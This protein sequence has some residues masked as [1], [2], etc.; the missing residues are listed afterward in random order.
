[1]KVLSADTTQFETEQHK[2]TL[3]DTLSVGRFEIFERLQF[4]VAWGS[5]FEK[6]FN[7]VKKAYEK[8]NE[9]K[10]AD[11][12]VI[13]Y[14]AMKGIARLEE[15]PHPVLR[16]CTLFLVR[17]GE[18]LTVWDEKIADEK[19]ADWK[20]EG[21]NTDYFFALALNAVGGFLSAYKERLSDTSQSRTGTAKNS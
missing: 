7:N 9:M 1:M 12:S 2:Y 10:A 19:I 4:E 11:A 6:L 17:D 21:I 18:D 14:N 5:D 15:R 8:L 16:L 13:L 3:L 20:K